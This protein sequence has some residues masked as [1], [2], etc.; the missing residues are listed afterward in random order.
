MPK[1]TFLPMNTICDAKKGESILDVAINHDIPIQHAC[2]GFCACTTCQVIVIS[3]STSLSGLEEDEI[4][5]IERATSGQAGSRLGCQAK[6]LGDVTV[7]IVNLD[8]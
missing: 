7:Q 8:E 5:R 2:G 4:E 1:V 6:V 3:G